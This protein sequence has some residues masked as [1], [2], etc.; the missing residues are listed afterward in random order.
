ML[1]SVVVS[2]GSFVLVDLFQYLED[3]FLAALGIGQM[4]ARE[5]MKE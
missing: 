4:L 3:P 1:T 2:L 5:W